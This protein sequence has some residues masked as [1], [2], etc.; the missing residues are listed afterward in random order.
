M[1]THALVLT[2]LLRLFAWVLSLGALF[3]GIGLTSAREIVHW[4]DDDGVG[5]VEAV[6]PA[7][8]VL[9][10]VGVLSTVAVAMIE[11]HRLSALAAASDPAD[12]GAAAPAEPSRGV[13][14]RIAESGE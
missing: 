10:G 4:Y 3:T 7:G 14:E 5:E 11:A 1:N 6:W 12:S 13:A 9:L 8:L 2:P